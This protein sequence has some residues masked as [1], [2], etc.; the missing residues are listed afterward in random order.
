MDRTAT[1]W[2][3]IVG[4]GAGGIGSLSAPA[5]AA[6][7]A[8]ELVVGSERQLGL[9]SALVHGETMSWS[10]PMLDGVARVLARRGQ[11]TCIL[12]SGDP[13]HFG[14]G[15]ML[16]RSLRQGDLVCYPSPSSMSLAASR[17]GWP[18]QETEIVSLHGRDLSAVIRFLTPGRRILALSWDRH[19]PAK[20]A[21]LLVSRGFGSS[22]LHVLEQLGSAQERQRACVA[23]A[24][25]LDDVA[26]LNLVG[27]EVEAERTALVIPARGSL[28]DHAFEHDG[29]L[30]K[31]DIRALTLSALAPYPGALLWDVGAGA[32]SVAI[33]WLLAHPSCR[34]IAVE[35]DSQRCAR[36][37]R[38]A[39]AL[40]TPTLEIVEG[41]A[42]AVLTDLARPDAVFIEGGGGDT[43]VFEACFRALRPGGRLVMN[44]V[45]LESEALLYALY[46][47]HGGELRRFSVQSAVPL[48]SMTGF[49][50]ALPVT[51]WRLDKP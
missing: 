1:A 4:I 23:S 21:E 44:A 35:R 30:T 33:E 9:V 15:S 17:L 14:V 8:A 6:I 5:R 11:R 47:A 49:R 34:A 20:L 16:A 24:F 41:S 19:T 3:S 42:P 18:L 27:I 12:G 25:A 2:L 36:I 28:P 29:Q 46:R 32:G 26:D 37:R 38:N 43:A 48:G 50:P 45:A 10:S 51:Q 22:Q 40:G 7:E 31:Q 39:L 13:F